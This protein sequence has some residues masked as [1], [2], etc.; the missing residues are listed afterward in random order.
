MTDPIAFWRT[1]HVYFGHLLDLLRKELDVF[2]SGERP[3]YELVQDVLTYLRDY[4]DQYHHPREDAAF[5]RLARRC[6]DIAPLVARLRQEHRI[7]AH[8]GESLLGLVDGILEGAMVPRAQVEWELATYLVYY[9]SHIGNEEQHVLD[10]AGR[11][12]SEADWVAVNAVGGTG[13]DPVF[14]H[15]PQERYRELRRRIA[16]E[17]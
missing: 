5:E 10:R 15:K 1:E 13:Q 17:A 3:N 16:Q 11:E 14:G 2:H 12:L 6:P 4:S 9:R 7:I 8:A